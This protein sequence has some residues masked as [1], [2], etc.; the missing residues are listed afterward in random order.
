MLIGCEEPQ[1]YA[2][3]VDLKCEG[4]SGYERYI[5]LSSVSSNRRGF[6]SQYLVG[7]D[8]QGK[9][10]YLFAETSY[11]TDWGDEDIVL[12]LYG[13]ARS[14]IG[15]RSL[16]YSSGMEASSSALYKCEITEGVQAKAKL[17]QQEFEELEKSRKQPL[18]K[19]QI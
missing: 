11:Q 7:F 19:R 8:E 18:P 3:S 9:A 15:R 16:I 14:T 17:W 5:H 6:A 12:K 10:N 4:V 13:K 2:E 1:N